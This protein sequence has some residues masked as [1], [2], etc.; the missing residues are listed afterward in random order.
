MTLSV[1]AEIDYV[2]N[3]P[4]NKYKSEIDILDIA[5]N[6][7]LKKMLLYKYNSFEYNNLKSVSAEIASRFNKLQIQEKQQL[8]IFKIAQAN[9]SDKYG[10]LK[11]KDIKTN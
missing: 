2:A 1:Q 4:L 10:S 9:N 11:E 6:N 8:A 3:N 5:N 7:V